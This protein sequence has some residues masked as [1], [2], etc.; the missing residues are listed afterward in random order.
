MADRRDS[1]NITKYRR[2]LNINIGMIIFGVMIIYMIILGI[3]YFKT[4][5]LSGYEVKE[6]SLS[7]NN[8]Y[9]GIAVREEKVYQTQ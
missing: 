6:G 5:H 8:V 9:R 4:E 1:N 3:M 7:V 2:P